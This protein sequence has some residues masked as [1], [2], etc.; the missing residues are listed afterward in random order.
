MKFNS[1]V[2]IQEP[3]KAILVHLPDG[4]EAECNSLQEIL[5]WFEANVVHHLTTEDDPIYVHRVIKLNDDRPHE[6]L[7]ER[8]N[9]QDVAEFKL[10][11]MHLDSSEIAD[12]STFIHTKLE[13]DEGYNLAKINLTTIL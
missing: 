1:V 5:Q 12:E 10:K 9:T 4:E 8:L 3:R 13:L 11:F 6:I 7:L 2:M